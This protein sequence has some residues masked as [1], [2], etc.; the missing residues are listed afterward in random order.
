MEKDREQGRRSNG[1]PKLF[2]LFFVQRRIIPSPWVSGEKLDG[3]AA[4]GMGSFNHLGEP[5]GNGN[6]E[7]KPHPHPLKKDQL[8]VTI[9]Y[10]N[11][12]R[13]VNRKLKRKARFFA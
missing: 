10:V 11:S 3:F 6:M 13:I 8:E 2:H 12:I 9:K 5:S 7:P 4:P 1:G